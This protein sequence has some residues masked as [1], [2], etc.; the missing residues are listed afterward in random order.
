MRKKALFKDFIVE[1]RKTLNRFLS[2]FFIVALG[3][4]FFAGIRAADPDMRY[5]GDAYFDEH[6]L[7]D[8]KVMSTMGL[9]DK[10]IDAIRG[11]DGVELVDPVY[12]TDVMAQIGDAE[13]VVRIETLPEHLNIVDVVEGRLPEK[14]N[15]CV[16]DAD[17]MDG[18]HLKVGDTFKVRSGNDKDILDTLTGETFTITGTCTSPVY[19]SFDRGTTNVGSGEVNAFVYVNDDAFSQEVYSK[20]WVSVVGAADQTA[21]TEGYTSVVEEV[22]D[23]IEEIADGRCDI[24]YADIINEANEKIEEAE[25]ELE[26]AKKEADE[27]LG[28]AKETLESGE[29]ELESGKQEIEDAQNQ[30]AD[31]RAQLQDNEGTLSSGWAAYESGVAE[32]EQGKRELEA[33]YQTLESSRQTL[34]DGE[35]AI[36]A[37]EEELA[38]KETELAAAEEGLAQARQ[39]IDGL[40]AGW[41]AYYEGEAQIQGMQAQ[42][43]GLNALI[44]AGLATEEQIAQAAQLEG[45]IAGA[46]AELSANKAQL[47]V[48]EEKRPQAEEALSHETEITEGRTQ[49]ET[50]KAELQKQKD[51]IAEGRA[52]YEAGL[53]EYEVN[54]QKLDEAEATLQSSYAQLI[55]GQSQYD[56]GLA[57]ISEAEAELVEARATIA[58]NEQKIADGWKEYEDGKRDAEDE[59]SD[60]EIK[61][62][63]AKNEIDGIAKPS[64]YVNDRDDDTDY[65]G[66]AENADRMKAIG[67]VFPIL[68]FLVAALISLTTMTRMVEEQRMQIGTLKALGYSG[69]DIAGK[70]IG[71]ALA[72]SLGGS[73]LGVLVG[74]KIF[75][76]IIVA[77]YKIMYM[78]IPNIVIPYEIKYSAMATLLAVACTVLASL[79]ACYAELASVPAELMRPTVPKTGKKVILEYLP[80]IWRRLNFTWKSTI[81]NLTRYKKRFFMTVFGIGGCMALIVTGYGLKDSIVDVVRMQF[82]EIQTYDIMAILDEDAEPDEIKEVHEACASDHRINEWTNGYMRLTKMQADGHNKDVYIYV[83]E[84]TEHLDA[85]LTF[86]NRTTGETWQMDENSVM[87]TEKAARD[88]DLSVGDTVTIELE[89]DQKVEVTLTDICENYLNHYIY[90]AP[91]KYKEIAGAEPEYNCIFADVDEKYIDELNDIG[92]DILDHEGVLTLNYTDNMESRVRDM[93]AVLDEVIIVLIVAAGLLAFV[94]LYN[95]NNININERRRELATLKVLGF[96]DMEV[97]QYVYRENIV[98]TLIGI[99]I[100]AVLGKWLHGFLVSTVEVEMTMFGRSIYMP[101]YGYAIALTVIFSLLVNLVM[102]FKLKNIDMVESMKSVE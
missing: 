44:A 47:D 29:A 48:L 15:E 53:A 101:S 93:V 11:V 84:R 68:F 38:A 81:R 63:D 86:R 17:V 51:T 66:Y 67:R 3:V 16:I 96:Y 32:L 52:Q 41:A 43:D 80:F 20:A 31:A 9:T 22:E 92:Q 46:Q 34:E 91:E 100:G 42:L 28:K 65:S 97:T 21:F 1:I 19:I 50:G 2:I 26:S 25:S 62:Q 98:L 7:M 12:M 14:E 6:R 56:S 37:A 23:R 35:A 54:K 88:L 71:Y 36:T 85:F 60:A 72:A 5:S 69:M 57:Q 40:D 55:D 58:E 102:Y 64:W 33:G 99:L 94:V 13:K 90:I 75:P 27:E 30:I 61:I 74:E 89:D 39:L 24:R 10:D 73:V 8:I 49:L 87:L 59:I 77:S 83:P 82:G 45:A 18:W 70:Y 95:L 76:Y 78:H 79:A 4:S